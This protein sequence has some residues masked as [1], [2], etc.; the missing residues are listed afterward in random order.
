MSLSTGSPVGTILQQDDIYVDGAPYVYFQ[1]YDDGHYLNAPDSDGF[2]W[3]LS[4]STAA[5]VYEIGCVQD[6]SLTE[7]VTIN[8]VRCDNIGDRAAI[9]RRNRLEFN[10]TIATLFGLPTLSKL[11][12]L[13]TVTTNSGEDEK[14]GVGDINNNRYYRVYLPK[15]YDEDEGD[16]VAITLHKCQFVDAWSIGMTLGEPWKING[17]KIY[18]FADASMPT[19]QKFATIIRGDS[20]IS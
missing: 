18:A 10:L 12:K 9:Q 17:I 5:P 4:G 20:D 14:V 2:Y 7:D 1:E 3:N 16:Y 11:L 13:G 8:M 19:A 15:V 6:V